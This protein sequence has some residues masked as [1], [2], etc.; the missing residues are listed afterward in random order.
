MMPSYLSE[1]AIL[2]IYP[3]YKLGRGKAQFFTPLFRYAEY[4]TLRE[5]ELEIGIAE[6]ISDIRI[7]AHI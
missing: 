4:R 2:S 1:Y 5:F 3:P 6:H 7:G